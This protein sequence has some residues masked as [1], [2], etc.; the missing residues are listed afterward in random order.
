MTEIAS[1]RGFLKLL[2]ASGATSVAYL[3]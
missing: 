1:R 3:D 2:S